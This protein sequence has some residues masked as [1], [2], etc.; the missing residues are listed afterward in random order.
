MELLLAFDNGFEP[1]KP[2]PSLCTPVRFSPRKGALHLPS[3]NPSFFFNP[4]CPLFFCFHGRG[5]GPCIASW[6]VSLF[7]YAT[8]SR[9]L[10]IVLRWFFFFPSFLSPITL[11]PETPATF[12]YFSFPLNYFPNICYFPVP[13]PF[14]CLVTPFF[15]HQGFTFCYS[16][17][18]RFFSLTIF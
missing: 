11:V 6:A 7:Y 8:F 14:P 18:Y 17:S 12:R 15:C 4:P 13:F 2:V 1:L 5:T 3:W 9:I 16:R 10:G